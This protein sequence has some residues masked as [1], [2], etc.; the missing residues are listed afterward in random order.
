MRN[1]VS[2]CIL[3]VVWSAPA[4]GIDE[5]SFKRADPET[6][7]LACQ[8]AQFAQGDQVVQAMKSRRPSEAL[9][10]LGGALRELRN[11]PKTAP[12]YSARAFCIHELVPNQMRGAG[13][14]ASQL[15]RRPTWVITDF[16][17]LGI[18]YFYYDPSAEWTLRK[19]PVDL[20][21]LAESTSIHDGDARLF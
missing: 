5:P 3:L 4:W 18:E 21:E 14:I 9:R 17:Q 15:S 1:V 7:V 13:R 11:T 6:Q 8:Q 12:L 16:E 10:V 2:L 20:R 19:D